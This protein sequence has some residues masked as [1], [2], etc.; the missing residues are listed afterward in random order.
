MVDSDDRPFHG[1]VQIQ[2]VDLAADSC[3]ECD[4]VAAGPPTAGA[5]LGESF[6]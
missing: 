2:L 4:D 5:P 6:C 3:P 1:F